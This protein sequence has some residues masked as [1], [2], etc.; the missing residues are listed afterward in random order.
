MADLEQKR[1]MMLSCSR[2]R[3]MT[4][5]SLLG[6]LTEVDIATVRRIVAWKLA[7]VVVDRIL[8]RFT[9]WDGSELVTDEELVSLD[10]VR[11]WLVESVGASE[12][13]NSEW[14]IFVQFP[15][16]EEAMTIV[17]DANWTERDRLEEIEIE[18]KRIL[19]SFVRRRED[20]GA[21][22]RFL[23]ARSYTYVLMTSGSVAMT[24]QVALFDVRRAGT[25]Q[26]R[27]VLSFNKKER[28]T[29][30]RIEV[31]ERETTA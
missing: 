18:W 15:V 8:L 10:E 6:E 30:Y 19:D 29:D 12:Q 7:E 13:Y 14:Y 20:L 5:R 9:F 1:A 21:I 27:I 24:P 23:E 2:A 16:F 22:V 17:Y 31:Q 28:L 11:A 25:K 26:V 3:D 4:V